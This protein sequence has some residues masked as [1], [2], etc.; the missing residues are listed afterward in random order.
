MTGLLETGVIHRFFFP[1][2]LSVH[3]S[4]PLYGS[5]FGFAIQQITF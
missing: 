3:R 2:L 1:A 4:R 5:S